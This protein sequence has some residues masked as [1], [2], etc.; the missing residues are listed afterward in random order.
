MNQKPVSHKYIFQLFEKLI[1][2]SKND[3][4]NAPTLQDLM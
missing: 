1:I 4:P 3:L 2:N